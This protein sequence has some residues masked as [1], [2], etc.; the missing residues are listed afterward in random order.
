MYESP[1][2]LFTAEFMGSNNR[3]PAR[4]VARQGGSARLQVEGMALN[5]TARGNGASDPDVDAAALIRV[6]E[7]RIGRTPVDNGIQLPLSTCMYLGD[8]WEC[9]FKHGNASVRAYSKY[10]VDPGQ[11][12]LEMPA[13]KLWVF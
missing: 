5:A 4:V 11:Y 12:W 9:L 6:E 3:L 1:D 13:E 7:V 10:R 2:T 8:R